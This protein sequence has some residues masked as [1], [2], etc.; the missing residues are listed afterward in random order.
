MP[1]LQG[2]V[3]Q[4]APAPLLA[5]AIMAGGALKAGEGARRNQA[6]FLKA[7]LSFGLLMSAMNCRSGLL[8]ERGVS[9]YKLFCVYR[10]SQKHIYY[11]YFPLSCRQVLLGT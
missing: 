9:L 2:L 1:A 3:A 6:E 8:E 5:V 7:F 4:S 10:E 11:R